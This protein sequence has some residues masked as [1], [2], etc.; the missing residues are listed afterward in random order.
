MFTNYNITVHLDP[1][2]H[3]LAAQVELKLK[4]PHAGRELEFYLHRDLHV[5]ID[6]DKVEKFRRHDQPFV[7]APDSATWQVELAQD[8]AAGEVV[9][10]C[11]DYTGTLPQPF[12][13]GWETNRLTPQWVEL[14]MYG[15]W[16]P[17][18]NQYGAF[19]YQVKIYID[20]GYT[21]VGLGNTE[22][23][24]D[25]WLLTSSQ[26][27]EDIVLTAA[28]GLTQAGGEAGIYVFCA[29]QEDSQ[30]ARQ[31][32]DDARWT[33]D[34][35]SRWLGQ[36]RVRAGLTVVMAP[37]DK[38]GGYA[39]PGFVVMQGLDRKNFIHELAHLWWT[40]APV[41][42][43]EDWLN[44][45]FAE[46][47]AVRALKELEGREA[48]ERYLDNKRAHTQGLPPIR[49]LPRDHKDAWLV[50]YHKGALILHQLQQALGEEAFTGLLRR[51]LREEVDTT[52]GLIALISDIAGEGQAREFANWLD[53]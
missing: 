32:A 44:E 45:A 28:E 39:R 40:G 33:L 1:G 46:Y 4:M 34:Y 8:V 14:G 48:F 36:R 18:N 19:T 22:R 6:G 20:Q 13:Q 16:F 41:D 5:V 37:R 27:V 25:H 7:F 30:G 35:F 47:S 50:L 42:S 10:V 38:G 2:R 23:K 53:N 24:T 31:L 43:W 12:P 9:E 29:R 21:I 15:P 11:F 17:W 3:Q 51:C 52:D 49:N 26:P